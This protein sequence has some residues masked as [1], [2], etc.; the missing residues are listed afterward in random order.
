MLSITGTLISAMLSE[1]S[2]SELIFFKLS[3]NINNKNLIEQSVGILRDT[4]I[5]AV[6]DNINSYPLPSSF[7][8]NKFT[9]KSGHVFLIPNL[10]GL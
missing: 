2:I 7:K 10:I 3:V 4:F 6:P 8:Q 9:L 5:D 1:F